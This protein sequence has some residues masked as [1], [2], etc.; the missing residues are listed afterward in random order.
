MA[1]P[2]VSLRPRH[3]ARKP[4]AL[5]VAGVPALYLRPHGDG[6]HPAALLLHGFGNAH[7]DAMMRR[8]GQR[9]AERGVASLA[10]DAPR[11]GERRTPENWPPGDVTTAFV[12]VLLTGLQEWRQAVGW[13]LTRP[14]VD[15]RRVGLI[16]YSLGGMMGCILAGEDERIQTAAFCVTGD[17]AGTGHGP[18]RY[19][20]W[21]SPRPALFVNA[22]EDAV[23]PREAAEEL[24]AAAG[25]PKTVRWVTGGHLLAPEHCA[26]AVDWLAEHI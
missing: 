18:S 17:G 3:S 10:L 19:V 21:I 26:F 2:R 14:E 1:P 12:E 7:K 16:G 22:T 8:F 23:I 20:R 24:H 15:A 25:E 9:L 6:P 5:A 13:L 4:D 11:H